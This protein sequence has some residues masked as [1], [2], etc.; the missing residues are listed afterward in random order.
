MLLQLIPYRYIRLPAIVV[1]SFNLIFV[2]SGVASIRGGRYYS[3]DGG[4]LEQFE[5]FRDS[6]T[7]A[8]S[9]DVNAGITA[10]P[11]HTV[12]DV[13]LD[14][15]YRANVPPSESIHSENHQDSVQ[16]LHHNARG[17]RVWLDG[18]PDALS[19]ATSSPEFAPS[20][21]LSS[22]SSTSGESLTPADRAPIE[23][24]IYAQDFEVKH[25]RSSSINAPPKPQI[26]LQLSEFQGDHDSAPWPSP[27]AVT[28]NLPS[29]S[30]AS[31]GL[32]QSI[33]ILDSLR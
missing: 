4:V 14:T 7:S 23:R 18:L 24:Y 19:S 31:R 20:D 9:S 29:L 15:A 25:N 3:G 30:K 12:Q 5:A 26:R 27:S 21:R 33:S 28:L 8:C 16:N 32:H 10:H 22:P 1:G 6:A 17:A 11:T 13:G 2:S